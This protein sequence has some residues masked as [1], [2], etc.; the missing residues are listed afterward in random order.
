M[1]GSSSSRPRGRAQQPQRHLHLARRGRRARPVHHQLRAVG[2]HRVLGDHAAPVGAQVVADVLLDVLVPAPAVQGGVLLPELDVVLGAVEGHAQPLDGGAEEGL[3][4]R[5]GVHALREDH[6]QAAVH[7][8]HRARAARVLHRGPGDHVGTHGV[9]GQHRPLDPDVVEHRDQ[10]G[11]VGLQAPARRAPRT[12]SG[13]GRA[14]RAPARSTSG[15]RSSSSRATG[16]QPR[17]DAVMPCAATTTASASAGAAPARATCSSPP[18]TG[19]ASVSTKG[20]TRFAEY[21]AP[22]GALPDWL[23]LCRRAA[24]RAAEAIEREPDRCRPRWTAARAE[25]P[26]W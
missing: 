19:T 12:R 8:H 16:V 5:V 15:R 11:R 17:C 10:V 22:R 25:T 3:E 23:E 21:A 6:R 9:A 7:Q 2:A 13:R 4:R 26:R 18:S 14:G 1:K 20:F 24:G